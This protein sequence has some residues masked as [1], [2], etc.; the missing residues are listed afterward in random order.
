MF[1]FMNFF[2]YSNDP[3]DIYVD[4]QLEEKHGL[5]IIRKHHNEEYYYEY[6]GFKWNDEELK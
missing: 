4:N 3:W 6:R 5:V 1:N 2:E